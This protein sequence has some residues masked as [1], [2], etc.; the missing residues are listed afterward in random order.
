MSP[1]PRSPKPKSPALPLRS[2]SAAT[3]AFLAGLL[4][5]APWRVEAKVSSADGLP[6][7]CAVEA[8]LGTTLATAQELVWLS[9][10]PAAC[11]H[12]LQLRAFGLQNEL[13]AEA[14]HEFAG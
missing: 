9:Q 7:L 3:R 1:K 10:A 11:A 4:P 8:V 14:W 13:L 5:Q 12:V 6:L 2:V